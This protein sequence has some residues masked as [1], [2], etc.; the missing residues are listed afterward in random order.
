ML[1]G[2]ISYNNVCSQVVALYGEKT[3]KGNGKV[4][5]DQVKRGRK[6]LFCGPILQMKKHI[7]FTNVED[8]PQSKL[9]IVAPMV[10]QKLN[11]NG[12]LT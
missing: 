5:L 6:Y 7:T 1:S 10:F 2:Y 9:M 12:T 11:L 4:F 8:L 3:S